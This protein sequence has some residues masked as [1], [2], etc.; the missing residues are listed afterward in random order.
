MADTRRGLG[1]GTISRQMS[2]AARG[3]GNDMAAFDIAARLRAALA[4][5]AEAL[6]NLPDS[7]TV[8]RH[9]EAQGAR[10]VFGYTVRF[11]LDGVRAEPF[12]DAAPVPRGTPAPRT[13]ITDVFE[14]QAGIRVVAELPGVVSEAVRCRAEPLALD[15]VADGP[16]HFAK[17]V[18]LPRACVPG[19]LAWRCANGILEATLGYAP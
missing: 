13:P 5:V 18:E 2:E 11:G 7:G 16:P 6:G 15:I 14:E 9:A 10:A 4:Q 12:G 17:R 8:S 19:T 1:R 3:K